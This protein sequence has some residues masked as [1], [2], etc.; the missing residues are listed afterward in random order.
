MSAM[1]AV[2]IA[3]ATG[4]LKFA[5]S[6]IG[7]PIVNEFASIKSVTKDLSELRDIHGAISSWLLTFHADGAKESDPS[8][9]WVTKLENIAD[10]ICNLLQEVH[11]DADR[12]K[13]ES[14]GEKL[15]A[16]ADCITA[17]PKLC[18]YRCKIAHRIK[19]IKVRFAAIVKQ[20]S[21]IEA[22]LANYGGRNMKGGEQPL[23]TNGEEAKILQRDSNDYIVCK[24]IE[25]SEGGD[26]DWME[27]TKNQGQSSSTESNP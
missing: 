18:M 9:R 17:K 20:R 5:V 22:I 1:Q 24:P 12:N 4:L 8:V 14:G 21:D 26:E 16:I 13:T 23:P 27:V 15:Y 2:S 11:L 6:K 3:L 25:S 19:A 10:D 7:P